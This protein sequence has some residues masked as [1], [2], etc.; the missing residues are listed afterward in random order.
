MGSEAAGR[1]IAGFLESAFAG[2]MHHTD[3]GRN[4]A[5]PSTDPRQRLFRFG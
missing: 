4:V 3:V 2:W 1:C 5:G